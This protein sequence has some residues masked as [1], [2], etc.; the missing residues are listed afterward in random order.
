MSKFGRIFAAAAII[1]LAGC[2]AH[3]NP[4]HAKVSDW[5]SEKHPAVSLKPAQPR[6]DAQAR[7]TFPSVPKENHETWVSL[8]RWCK[9]NGLPSPTRLE[10]SAPQEF[11][12]RATNGVFTFRIGDQSAHWNGIEL[13]L[14]FAPVL[15]DSQPFMHA[16]DLKK[17]LGP[18]TAG[19]PL[20]VRGEHPVLVLD[21]GHGGMNAG[22]RSVL[23]NDYEKD[24]TLDWARRLRPLLVAKGWKVFLTRTNDT[25]ITLSNRV[26]F[27]EE[28][29]ADLFVSLHFNSAGGGDTQAGLETYCLSPAGMPST[30]TRGFPDDLGLSFPN[31]TFDAANLQLALRIHQALLDSNHQLDRGIRRARFLG[32]LRNQQRPAILVEG[33]YL[34][35]QAEARRIADPNFRQQLA[36]AMAHTLGQVISDDRR[37]VPES[38]GADGTIEPAT[39]R[40]ADRGL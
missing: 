26:M 19:A 5:E 18:L 23:S 36:V 10:D 32:V 15:I 7:Q 34:S 3:P 21:P 2:A 4:N 16:L 29:H 13:R 35:N 11:E 38:A 40:N 25:D 39:T 20:N 28:H 22:T 12:V 14:G 6:V 30:V 1:A 9:E 31:N 27:A 33:G 8:A 37:P 24:F 17:N